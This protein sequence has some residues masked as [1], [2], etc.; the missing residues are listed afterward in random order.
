MQGFV[1]AVAAFIT[2]LLG[3]GGYFAFQARKQAS[4]TWSSLLARLKSVHRE[5]IARVAFD[6]TGED[7]HGTAIETSELS[8]EAIWNLVG[9]MEGLDALE[10]NCD[11]LIDLACY[12]Q[13]W[14]PEAVVTAEELRL[15]AREIKWHIERLRGAAVT[16]H[17]RSAFPEYAQRAVATYYRMTETVLALYEQAHV[18]GLPELKAAL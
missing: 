17:L 6:F 9:G 10:A 4:A 5:D 2:L 15:S 8:P 13:R 16:G 18:P 12:V 11:V 14:Y 7:S 1:F 3:I